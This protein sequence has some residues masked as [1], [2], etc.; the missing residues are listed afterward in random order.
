MNTWRSSVKYDVI[1]Y[2]YNHVQIG[3]ITKFF[4]IVTYVP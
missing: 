1:L 3:C 2:L 4:Y